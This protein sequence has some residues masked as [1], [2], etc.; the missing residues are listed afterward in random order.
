MRHCIDRRKSELT[1]GYLVVR[2]KGAVMTTSPSVGSAVVRRMLCGESVEGD[3]RCGAWLHCSDGW[4]RLHESTAQGS[5]EPVL[6]PLAEL[7]F[8]C[9]GAG[10]VQL[11]TCGHAVHPHCFP[12]ADLPAEGRPTTREQQCP[13]CASVTNCL[14]PHFPVKS[15]DIKLAIPSYSSS[16]L[17]SY[18][19]DIPENSLSNPHAREALRPYALHVCSRIARQ[20]RADAEVTMRPSELRASAWMAYCASSSLAYTLL[21]AL[22]S[23]PLSTL[24][25]PDSRNILLATH[26]LNTIAALISIINTNP[27]LMA[28]I[29]G[30]LHGEVRLPT[31]G[32]YA[33][34]TVRSCRIGLM[35]TGSEAAFDLEGRFQLTSRPLLSWDLGAICVLTASCFMGDLDTMAQV[36]HLLIVARLTQIFIE[37]NC[38]GLDETVV[39]I[40][41]I[42]SDELIGT[43]ERLRDQVVQQCGL[44]LLTNRP[45]GSHLVAHLIDRLT[46]FLEVA[47][48]LLLAAEAAHGVTAISGAHSEFTGDIDTHLGALG[49]PVLGEF[50]VSHGIRELCE[51]W[52][53]QFI[54][55]SCDKV[56]NVPEITT[57]QQSTLT[58]AQMP[59]QSAG[60][61]E[62]GG[63]FYRDDA[64]EY[65][66]EDGMN[67]GI[68]GEV[69]PTADEMLLMLLTEGA[70]LPPEVREYL[71]QR[72]GDQQVRASARPLGEWRMVG[73]DPMFELVDDLVAQS[74]DT[75]PGAYTGSITQSRPL[76][77]SVGY[78]T[79]ALLPDLSHMG[80]GLSDRIKAGFVPLPAVFTDLYC[81]ILA[82]VRTFRADVSDPAMCLLCGRVLHA[83]NRQP[84]SGLTQGPGECTLHAKGGPGYAH[85]QAAVPLDNS[86]PTASATLSAARG[87]PGSCPPKTIWRS[88]GYPLGVVLILPPR[89]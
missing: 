85:Q 27:G 48:L 88:R 24:S 70:D 86:A 76:L 59:L 6:F 18:R 43:T 21:S 8:S 64:E 33:C 67:I 83:G 14:L 54:S 71:S 3:E 62:I 55:Y 72:V 81:D 28:E 87:P 79:S 26:S 68:A 46:P 60:D 1:R 35:Y 25:R 57:R 36:V 77:N 17:L 53:K 78:P 49:M 74:L 40:D 69:Q 13:L 84:P 65:E 19:F 10:R 56:E 45:G 42:Y 51:R 2:A 89:R 7:Q 30:L 66:E 5:S 41:K 63:G 20:A 31:Q 80:L 39:E 16:D 82:M 12:S 75:Y 29:S 38:T 22:L 73:I 9:F 34:N 37:P 50:L 4:V 52:A 32:P 23:D 11:S 58:G 47:R 61:T 15:A 44:Q